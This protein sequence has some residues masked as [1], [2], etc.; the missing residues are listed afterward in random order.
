M[1][2]VGPWGSVTKHT[3]RNESFLKYTQRPQN[4]PKQ[5]TRDWKKRTQSSLYE[6]T[7]WIIKMV[8]IGNLWTTTWDPIWRVGSKS[9][10]LVN[11][12]PRRTVGI[13][14][15]SSYADRLP[16]PWTLNSLWGR[17]CGFVC[18]VWL[19]SEWTWVIRSKPWTLNSFRGRVCGLVCWVRMGSEWTLDVRS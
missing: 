12:L 15:T 9:W 1:Q 4:T 3:R 18:W 17:A 11:N 10:R 13:Q 19:G 7:V 14:F 16:K 6:N 2:K 5:T 8:W